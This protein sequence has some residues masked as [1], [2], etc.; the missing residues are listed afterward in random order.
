ME[1]K[2][3]KFFASM[4]P[5]KRKLAMLVRDLFLTADKKVEE[6]IKWGNLTFLYKG[7]L[8]FV[9]TFKE[10]DYINLGFM[11]AVKLADPKSLFEGT[12]KSMRH[13]KISA[14]KDIPKIQLKKWVKEAMKLNEMLKAK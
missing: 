6:T 1:P 10:T 12:G 3:E 11:Q 2:I 13:I 8:A 9:Y 5:E 7:N 4:P 14:E